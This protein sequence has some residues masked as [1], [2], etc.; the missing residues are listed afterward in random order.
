MK[1]PEYAVEKI[2]D[3]VEALDRSFSRV[4]GLLP[5]GQK[6][7]EVMYHIVTAKLKLFSLLEENKK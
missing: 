3:E 2:Q 1:I 7:D 5:K 6:R 4:W